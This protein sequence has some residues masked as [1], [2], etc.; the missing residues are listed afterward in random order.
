M[1]INFPL[2]TAFAASHTLWNTAF[3]FSLVSRYIL[4]SFLISSVTH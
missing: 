3:S 4:I 1:A 2:K